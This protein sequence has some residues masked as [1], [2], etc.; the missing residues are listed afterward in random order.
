M[1]RLKS[2]MDL[3][4]KHNIDSSLP[5]SLLIYLICDSLGHVGGGSDALKNTEQL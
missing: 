5:F 1:I 3:T 2:F 4:I